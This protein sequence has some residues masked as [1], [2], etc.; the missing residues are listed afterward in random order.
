MF[1]KRRAVLKRLLVAILL[2]LTLTTFVSAQEADDRPVSFRNFRDASMFDLIDRIA[3]QLGMNYL[4]D[5]AV[6][7]GTITINT[8]GDMQR[9]DLMPLLETILRMNGAAAVEV[10]GIWRI[11]TLSGVANAPLSPLSTRSPGDLPEAEPMV[12]NAVR[13]NYM[14]AEELS[15][16]LA[17]FLGVGG[18]FAVVPQANTL[19]LLDNARN[20][21][22]TLDLI[23]LFDTEEMANQRMRLFEIENSLASTVA[24][25]L[26]S[27]FGALSAGGET[28]AIQFLPLARISSVLVVSSSPQIFDQ[29]EEWIK[30]LDKSATSGGVQNFVY[31]VQYGFATSLAQTLLQLYGIPGGYGGGYGGGGY[32]GGGYGGGQYG[33][34]QYGGGQFGGGQFGGGGG[35]GFPGGGG[36]QFG[37]GQFGGGQFG[38]GGFG[39]GGF[40][41]GG[42]GGGFIQLPGAQQQVIPQAGAAGGT[43]Q[44]GALLGA[45]AGT[46]PQTG[47][48]IVPDYV[49]NLIVVQSTK[50][51]WE[52]IHKTLQELDFAPRQVLIDAQVYEVKLEGGLSMGVSAFLRARGTD[53][54]GGDRKLTGSLVDGATSLTLGALVGGTRELAL[55]LSAFQSTGRAKVISAPSLMATDNLAASITVGQSI[56]ILTSQAV[57]GI[58]VG[59]DSQFTQTITQVQTGVTLSITPRVNASGIVT[60]LID[61]EVSSPGPASSG[62]NSPSI[63]RR[64]VN[65]QV[66]VADGDTVAIGGI[67]QETQLYGRDSVPYLGRI[68]VL[69]HLF[70]STTRSTAKTEL[71]I[72]LTPR[73]IYDETEM[74]SASNDLKD[75]MKKLRSMINK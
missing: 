74:V 67:I 48:R 20:M 29:V 36:G 56:P 4:I 55:A 61:Q 19:I 68:P 57:G 42:G 21:R 32:G 38:G 11:I 8:Y 66:T 47:I 44:T 51:E 2:A 71:I 59:G 30:R 37:G 18:Q 62:I 73:V 45:V 16:V 46:Q 5:P 63:D 39:G 28:S 12:M 22:R 25:E 41:G 13:L 72:L 3:Q 69:G 9:S 24:E 65:T 60:M 49:N 40:G 34:G 26:E 35:R 27:V 17:P 33:G 75:R 10:D 70:G 7:D 58:Q 50:Q 1:G 52:V 6:A 54:T 14:V 64:S 23:A 43:D 53:G 31:K 15:A